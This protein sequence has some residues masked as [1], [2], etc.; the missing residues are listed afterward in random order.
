[1]SDN[2]NK[3]TTSHAK[4]LDLDE[5][6][7]ALDRA[8]ALK[9]EF[10]RAKEAQEPARAPE[11]DRLPAPG[12]RT[13][14]FAKTL[15]ANERKTALERAAPL[16]AQFAR[17][18]DAPEHAR[19]HEKTRQPESAH[20]LGYGARPEAHLRPEGEI[21]RA[22]DKQ[23]D[24]EQREKLIQRLKE[25]NQ[26]CKERAAQQKARNLNKDRHRTMEHDR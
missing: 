14:S 22:V 18:N 3:R 7:T 16:K 15:D 26:A 23:I 20:G 21:R 25:S 5:H 11:K 12:D 6:K 24:K 9:D 19:E 2:L 4:S 1:M 17:A 8:R 10:E 13:T